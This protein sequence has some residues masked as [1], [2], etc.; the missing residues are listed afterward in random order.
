[1]SKQYGLIGKDLSYSLSKEIHSVV[2]DNYKYY[3]CKTVLDVEKLI[4]SQELD[5]FNVT[6]PY[7]ETVMSFISKT[8]TIAKEIGS[9]NTVVLENGNYVGYNTDYIGI[10]KT[11]DRLGIDVKT[12]NFLILGSGGSSKS[13]EYV[14]KSK[15]NN[16]YYIASRTKTKK[17]NYITYDEIDRIKSKINVIVNATPIGMHK[18][19]YKEPLVDVSKFSKLQ[20]VFDLIYNPNNTKLILEAKLKG[21]KTSNG[22]WMLISQALAAEECFL[23]K[24][25]SID[26]FLLLEKELTLKNTNIVLYGIAGAGKSSI[27]EKLSKL[28]GK[29]FYD[30]DMLIEQKTNMKI[31]EIFKIFGEE[32]FRNLE[33]EII[34]D[35]ATK[36]NC[37]IS[38]G[39]GAVLNNE[40]VQKLKLNGLFVYV[41]RRLNDIETLGRPLYEN[42][43]PKELYEERKEIYE[44]IEDIDFLN[45]DKSIDVSANRCKDLIMKYFEIV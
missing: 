30:T 7:K 14:L 36:N 35:L 8:D 17:P 6:I 29:T 42:K 11:F 16:D 44:S 28:L 37:C 32:Y 25:I 9:V 39:G 20:Y 19:I 5:G 21:I 38:L 41:K 10:I 18:Y 27:G 2:N 43:T 40:S 23:D 45:D 3:P 15:G 13:V 33:K 12:S 4:A 34:A 22:L 1:M 31:P 24:E 26:K